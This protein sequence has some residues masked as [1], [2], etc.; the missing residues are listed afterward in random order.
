MTGRIVDG[1][2]GLT[3]KPRLTLEINENEAFETAFD[4]L[5]E[6]DKIT[7][8]LKPYREKRSRDANAYCFALIDKIAEKLNIDKKD[9]YREAIRNIGG[10]SEIVC[11][12]NIAVESLISAWSARGL[13][14]QAETFPSKLAGCTN[15]ILYYGSSTYNTM[16]MSRLIDAIVNECKDLG[17]ETM[18][19]TEL[20][21]LLERWDK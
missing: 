4:E 16:Q 14:W 21:S 13:G 2:R 8:E 17:I 15:V 18:P 19:P 12:R 6:K 10:V 11:V 3:G 9:V 5:H 20:K 7:I 1:S